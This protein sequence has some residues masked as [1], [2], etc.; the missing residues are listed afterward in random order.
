[1]DEGDF[2][3]IPRPD[4][5]PM[6][7][8]TIQGLNKVRTALGMPLIPRPEPGEEPK[9][10]LVRVRPLRRETLKAALPDLC[11]RLFGEEVEEALLL[12]SPPVK[13]L[14][15]FPQGQVAA[16]DADGQ[17]VPSEQEPAWMVVLKDKVARGVVDDRTIVHLVGGHVV[18]LGEL[19]R[20]HG[21]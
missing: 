15:F 14:F 1:M 17:Q 4:G 10:Y 2:F 12:G 20:R 8:L 6:R 3:S 7:G 5:R 13:N 21:F 11:R 9:D 16:T 18:E 19:R